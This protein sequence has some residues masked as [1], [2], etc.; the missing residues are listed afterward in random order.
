MS[1]KIFNKYN[2]VD[3]LVNSAGVAIGFNSTNASGN[4]KTID[5]NITAVTLWSMK[6][7]EHMRIDKGGKGGTIINV[8]SIYGIQISEFYPVYVATKFAVVAFTRSLGHTYNYNRSK[9]RA[10][11]ICP[12]YTET[13]LTA[14]I[15]T[16]FEDKQ[17]L[18]DNLNA[19]K[20][21]V[22]QKVDS[23]G[24]GAVK[25]FENAESGTVWLIANDN[26]AV[27]VKDSFGI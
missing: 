21:A 15:D 4:K 3:V 20:D 18:E 17:L 13:E 23:V 25:V 10:V 14:N 19:A 8:G 12:G 11:T 7:W 16:Y 2:T 1:K 9:V 22:L 27:E 6:F 24:R 5:I 26:P